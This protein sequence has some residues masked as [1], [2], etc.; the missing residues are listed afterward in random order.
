MLF[1]D[2]EYYNS[3][4]F[5][6]SLKVKMK[7][8]NFIG[9]CQINLSAFGLGAAIPWVIL[10]EVSITLIIC[11]MFISAYKSKASILRLV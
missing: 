7:F 1:V 10:A 9:N 3:A 5:T 11:C 6:I 2:L 4:K 8:N